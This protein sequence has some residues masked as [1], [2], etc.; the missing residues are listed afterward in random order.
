MEYDWYSKAPEELQDHLKQLGEQ[1]FRARQIF[2]WLHQRHAVSFEEMTDLGKA[3]R[4]KLQGLEPLQPVQI[5]QK[6]IAADGTGT[7]KFL[8]RLADGMAI[9]S[10]LM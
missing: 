1:G 3:L 6:Q 8:I 7:G 5:E 10:V 9:E 2:K 4:E